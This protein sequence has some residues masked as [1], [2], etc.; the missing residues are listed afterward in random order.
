MGRFD[1]DSYDEILKKVG[2]NSSS[3]RS[4]RTAPSRP[5]RGPAPSRGRAPSRSSGGIGIS[6]AMQSRLDEIGSIKPE[7]PRS[8]TARTQRRQQEA[9]SPPAPSL[10]S[11]I[12][13][14]FTSVPGGLVDLGKGIADAA[15]GIPR[16]TSRLC[17]NGER[18]PIAPM[19]RSGRF[20]RRFFRQSVAR[21]SGHSP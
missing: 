12:G 6:E 5:S 15:I 9:A 14:A 1:G 17:A 8:S 19:D 3:R 7:A 13:S 11:Q 2:Q 16:S 10:W 18:Q 21:L 20:K 4:R